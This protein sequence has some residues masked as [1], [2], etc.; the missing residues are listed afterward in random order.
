VRGDEGNFEPDGGGGQRYGSPVTRTKLQRACVVVVG[1]GLVILIVVVL[2]SIRPYVNKR[3]P[4]YARGYQVGQ[5][6]GV[7]Q[8]S[9]KRSERYTSVEA[10]CDAFFDLFIQL[11]DPTIGTPLDADR[12]TFVAACISGAK[13][14]AV[15]PSNIP[16]PA[17]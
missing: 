14:P 6:I 12:S 13:S 10:G 8:D 4:W 1:V 7:I 16:T 3:S 11:D 15:L 5:G 9:P 17:V 2:A